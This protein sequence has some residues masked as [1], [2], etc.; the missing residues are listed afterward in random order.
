MV[1]RVTERIGS[2]VRRV[3]WEPGSLKVGGEIGVIGDRYL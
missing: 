2:S 1:R 3:K